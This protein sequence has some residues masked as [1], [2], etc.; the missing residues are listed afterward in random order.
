MNR[1]VKILSPEAMVHWDRDFGSL[2]LNVNFASCELYY[3]SRFTPYDFMAFSD[4]Y[5][6]HIPKL[7]R[8]M[9]RSEYTSLTTIKELF[10]VE[11]E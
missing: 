8:W 1:S 5:Y 6:M 10:Y 4:E 3:N 2:V 11:S 9:S 7:E